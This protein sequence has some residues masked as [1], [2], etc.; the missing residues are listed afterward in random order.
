MA[1]STV[2]TELR[3][4]REV[5]KNKDLFCYTLALA[6]PN[7]SDRTATLNIENDADFICERVTGHIIAPAN[8][9]GVRVVDAETD[10][11]LVGTV[12]GYAEH[13]LSVKITDTSDRPMT[14]GFIPLELILT[15]GYREQFNTPLPWKKLFPAKSRIKFEFK[16]RDTK[17]YGDPPT[18]LYHYVSLMFQGFKYNFTPGEAVT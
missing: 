3:H 12:V 15:P 11:P 10:Y 2:I 9:F 8:E 14:S 1:L 6:I 17:T 5:Q 13:G 18:V 4:Q 7:N 16:N